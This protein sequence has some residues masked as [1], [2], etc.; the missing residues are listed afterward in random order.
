MRVGVDKFVAV[1]SFRG[2]TW[3]TKLIGGSQKKLPMSLTDPSHE[4]DFEIAR[5]VSLH[6]KSC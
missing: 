6:Q 3:G 4:G 5:L 2:A 1:T